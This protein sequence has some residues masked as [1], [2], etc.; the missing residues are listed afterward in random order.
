MCIPDLSGHSQEDATQFYEV[1]V[2]G[3]IQKKLVKLT[4]PHP[5][6]CALSSHAL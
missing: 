4:F 1:L 3:L 5:A 6:K 2:Q